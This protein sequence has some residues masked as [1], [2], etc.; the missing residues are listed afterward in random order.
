MSFEVNMSSLVTL[1]HITKVNIV[2]GNSLIH[3]WPKSKFLEMSF[4]IL[5]KR[6]WTFQNNK[7]T[8]E[9]KTK[10]VRVERRFT[11]LD[12]NVHSFCIYL[13]NPGISKTRFWSLVDDDSEIRSNM[14]SLRHRYSYFHSQSFFLYL[15][16][17]GRWL[18]RL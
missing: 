11:S 14:K 3:C 16:F 12:S 1:L 2:I 17:F 15:D 6:G 10:E 8:K 5:L 7:W 9:G 13:I 4:R 18:D